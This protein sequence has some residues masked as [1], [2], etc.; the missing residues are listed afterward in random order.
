VGE[1]SKREDEWQR[2]A[3]AAAIA[4]VRKLTRNSDA[5]I[6]ENMPVGGLNDVQ[7]GWI[8]A[9]VI[10]AWI[11]TRA[12]QAA[13]EGL[14]TEITIRATGLDPNPWDAGAVA[15]ILPKLAD[16]P[17]GIDWSKPF[18][19]WPRENM[20]AF[21]T[22]ALGLVRTGIIARDLGGGSITRKTGAAKLDD[23]VP[24]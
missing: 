13:T 6:N 9:A 5:V 1:L 16:V 7:L 12:E 10:F 14:D 24:F 4:A 11:A 18:F 3:T 23:P 8:V 21:L 20:I 2:R 22:A 15:A 19:D 17:L